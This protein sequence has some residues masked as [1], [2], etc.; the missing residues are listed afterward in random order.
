MPATEQTWRDGKLLHK[1]FGAT[2]LLLLIATIWMFAKDHDREWKQYQ[3]TARKVDI[4]NTE[5]RTLQYDTEAW[6][7]EHEA[8]QERVRQ[9]QAQGID[10]KLIQAFI[11]EVE[12]AGDAGLP[13]RDLTR[14][15]AMNDSLN[16]AVSEARDVRNGR[17]ADDENEAITSYNERKLAAERARVQL[18]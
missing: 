16:V 14:L 2:S 18:D 17:N 12:N 1:V 5:W 3:D 6:H 11:L 8:L 13:V 7:R 9:T 15:N 10:P 4:I